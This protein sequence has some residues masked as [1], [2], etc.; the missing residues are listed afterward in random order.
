VT[1]RVKRLPGVTRLLPLVPR[2]VR[3][4]GY[5]WLRRSRLGRT[6]AKKFDA[7]PLSPEC[8]RRWIERFAPSNAWV[9]EFTG[10]DL[11]CWAE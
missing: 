7:P 1:D 9:A 10:E 11:S 8:R 4:A 2:T 5:Q 6:T 3:E